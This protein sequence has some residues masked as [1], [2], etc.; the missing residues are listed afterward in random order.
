ME[1]KSGGGEE[2][3]KIVWCG[4]HTVQKKMCFFEWK[5][6][7]KEHRILKSLDGEKREVKRA[8]KLRGEHVVMLIN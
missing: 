8:G 6:G 3:E 7:K 2:E 5:L 1:F 4:L